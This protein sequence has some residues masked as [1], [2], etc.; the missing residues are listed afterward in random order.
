MSKPLISVI[1]PVYNA[2]K[3]L[4]KSISSILN[5]TVKNFQL[6]IINDGSTDS[7]EK[8]LVDFA[9]KDHR[10]KLISRE[11]RGIVQTLNEGIK[12][13][14]GQW[15]AR[16]DADDIAC[17][18]RFEIQL[19]Q[20]S[21][22]NAE[23][24]GGAIRII[25]A[26]IPRSRKFYEDNSLIK[27]QTLFSSPLAHPTL[28]I[29]AEILKNHLYEESA[30]HVEDYDLWVRLIKAGVKFTNTSKI[31]LNYRLHSN[32]TTV[33]WKSLKNK[34]AMSVSLNYAKT[35]LPEY[36]YSHP[37]YRVILNSCGCFHK[38]DFFLAVDFFK[39]LLIKYPE[40]NEVVSGNLYQFLKRCKNLNWINIYKVCR[41]FNI[42]IRDFLILPLFIIW[43]RLN[44]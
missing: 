22:M 33:V 5:Q 23:V 38:R 15:I 27:T 32:Q 16:M 26:T 10:I 18:N 35:F 7:S 44:S 12:L 1:L 34:N 29:R 3:Y 37:G 19:R 2:E 13:A 8:I 14:E 21:C 6:I 36:L 43:S 39:E 41:N 25:G 9:K 20:L 30:L 17:K 4:Y 42:S 24:C 40:S 11:N 28:M 31:V